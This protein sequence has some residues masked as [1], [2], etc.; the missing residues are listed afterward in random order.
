MAVSQQASEHLF[1]AQS[2]LSRQIKI[3][4][5]QLGFALFD[6]TEKKIQLTPAGQ[7]LYQKIKRDLLNLDQ[8]VEMAQ[9]VLRK[10]KGA[11]CTLPIRVAL[12]WM[13]KKYNF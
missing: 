7:V 6:R 2:A 5:D 12:L 10:D 1:I 3:L 4:E 13:R 9:T 8:S 11:V